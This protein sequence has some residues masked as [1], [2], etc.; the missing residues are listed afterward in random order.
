MFLIHQVF[1]DMIRL[2]N[3]N[4]AA[5]SLANSAQVRNKIYRI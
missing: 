2:L 4:D 1:Q 3:E 5:Q